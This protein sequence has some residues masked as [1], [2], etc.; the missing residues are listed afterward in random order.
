[1]DACLDSLFNLGLLRGLQNSGGMSPRSTSRFCTACSVAPTNQKVRTSPL[2][3]MLTKPRSSMMYPPN[4]SRASLHCKLI[5]ILRGSPLLSMREAVL[6]V[7][8]KRQYRG[9]V[10]P[11]TPA[12]TGPTILVQS[13]VICKIGIKPVWIPI[14]SLRTSLGRCD[15]EWFF[16]AASK[17]KAIEAISPA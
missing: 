6:T 15:M 7:S 16:T 8:P 11:T 2:P 3:F 1:M 4:L 5:C 9:M 13:Q 12:T 10:S 14:R 17:S